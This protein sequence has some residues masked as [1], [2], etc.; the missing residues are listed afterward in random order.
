MRS[1]SHTVYVIQDLPE[2]FVLSNLFNNLRYGV[3]GTHEHLPHRTEII[4]AL[5]E[6]NADQSKYDQLR[7]YQERKISRHNCA[8]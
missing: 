5:T 4:S 1:T 7:D 2:T 8:V 3:C 6:A